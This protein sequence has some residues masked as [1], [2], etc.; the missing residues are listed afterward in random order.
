MKKEEGKEP[1]KIKVNGNILF[2]KGKK[3]CRYMCVC[4]L[5]PNH[6]YNTN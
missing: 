6:S 1:K 5:L 2:S 3:M 4:V